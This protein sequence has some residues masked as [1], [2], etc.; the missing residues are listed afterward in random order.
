MTTQE[1]LDNFAILADKYG[2]PNFSD[3]ETLVL[4]NNAQL[5]RL[6]RLLPDDAGGI[7]NFDLDQNTLMNVRP[8]IYPITT[9]M[10]SSGIITFSAVNTALRTAS[11]DN[12]CAIHRILGLRWTASSVS[13]P[14]KYTKSNNWDS[15]KRNSFKTGSIT[16]PRFMVDATNITLDPASTTAS[17]TITCLKTPKILAVGNTG[18]WDDTNA[19]QV[20]QI[21]LQLASQATRDQELLATIQ[22]SNVSK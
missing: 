21:A 11:G 4:L 19:N 3:D 14:V 12:G 13:Y 17:I 7:V 10:N 5:E 8:L 9:T 15:Y 18:D 1:L 6:R 2:S 22:N 20:I 16:A